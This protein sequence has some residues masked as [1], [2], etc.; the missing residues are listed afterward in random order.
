MLALAAEAG[1]VTL[2]W[3]SAPGRSYH[4]EWSDDLAGWNVLSQDGTPVVIATS[5]EST[6]VFSA[7]PPSSTG[8][9][10]YR[11]ALLP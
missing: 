4:I 2:T 5:S 10:F 7:F 8:R 11:I 3:R 1:G 9:Q 6:A